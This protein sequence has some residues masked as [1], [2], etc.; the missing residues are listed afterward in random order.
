MT[1]VA[2]ITRLAYITLPFCSTLALIAIPRPTGTLEQTEGYNFLYKG[3]NKNKI[4]S[5]QTSCTTLYFNI[6]QSNSKCHFA[7]RNN[8]LSFCSNIC[9]KSLNNTYLNI[10]EILLL[11]Y[12]LLEVN[13]ELNKQNLVSQMTTF[14]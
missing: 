5:C 1:A 13:N 9:S 12:R 11:M 8:K 10:T 3:K 2:R 6:G 4:P 14:Y 7:Q